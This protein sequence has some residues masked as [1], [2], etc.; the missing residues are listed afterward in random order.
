MDFSYL[1]FLYHP[2]H[3]LV[4]IALIFAFISL[5]IYK[6]PWLWGSFLAVSFIFAFICNLCDYKIFLVLIPLCIAHLVLTTEITGRERIIVIV[7]VVLLSMLLNFHFAPGFY[8][9]KLGTNIQISRNAPSISFFFNFDKPFIG[10]FPLALAIPL[11][12]TRMHMRSML[13][14]TLLF[15]VISIVV[16]LTCSL[17]LHII[18]FDLKFPYIFFAWLIKNLFFVTIPEEGFFRGFLQREICK[19]IPTKWSGP[20]GIVVTSLLFMVCEI[21]FVQDFFFLM[22]TFIA[23]LFY[24]A[25]YHITKSIESSIVCHYLVNVIHFFCFTYPVI[26]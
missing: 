26:G 24:G 10:F 20:I 25:V 21:C 13:F 6:K 15:S 7:I 22:L 9:W 12:S 19:Y 1:T 16:L 18:D 23:S 17:F 5:W 2:I 8:N 14:Q 11:I 4:F 3:T